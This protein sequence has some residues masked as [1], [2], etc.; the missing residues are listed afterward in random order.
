[1][2]T[3]PSV[4][5]SAPDY[6]LPR[7]QVYFFLPGLAKFS[8]RAAKSPSARRAAPSALGLE[9]KPAVCRPHSPSKWYLRLWGRTCVYSPGGGIWLLPAEKPGPRR[10]SPGR[11]SVKQG[12]RRAGRRLRVASR[13]FLRSVAASSRNY[14]EPGR[15]LDYGQ[16]F[17]GWRRGAGAG[18]R[19]PEPPIKG[20]RRPRPGLRQV[21]ES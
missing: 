18:C 3:T 4:F 1:M 15:T 14:P 12:Q 2:L 19:C 17:G 10:R 13:A 20:G 8:P 21:Q 11:A 9:I 16:V 7:P 5:F 6:S